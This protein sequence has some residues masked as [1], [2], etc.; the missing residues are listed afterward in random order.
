MEIVSFPIYPRVLLF[1]TSDLR[2]MQMVTDIIT[3]L[4]NVYTQPFMRKYDN[5]VA[6]FKN[7][8]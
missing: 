6:I 7:P 3:K 1:V 5:Q 2:K 4:F 8:H